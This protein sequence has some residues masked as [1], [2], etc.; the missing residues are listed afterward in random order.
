MGLAA[1]AEAGREAGRLVPVWVQRVREA[2]DG[3]HFRRPEPRRHFRPL[4]HEGGIVVVGPDEQSFAG[5]REPR[6]QLDRFVHVV[7]HAGGDADVEACL[8]RLAEEG[9]EVAQ[10]EAGARRPHHFLHDEALQVGAPVGLDCRDARGALLLEQPRVPALE[11]S[12]FEHVGTL[13]APEALEAPPQARVLE[14][15]DAPCREARQRLRQA[16]G[17]FTGVE[18]ERALWGGGARLVLV[19]DRAAAQARHLHLGQA[20]ESMEEGVH[21]RPFYGHA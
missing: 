20:A 12:E 21:R 10:Q 8:R 2:L 17:P 1:A 13:H 4:R 7:Q 6:Q 11:R 19:G 5:A 3:A 14:E 15:R 18:V 9:H 16:R